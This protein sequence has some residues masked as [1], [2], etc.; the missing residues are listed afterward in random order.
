MKRLIYLILI[1]FASKVNAQTSVY[2]PFP[3]HE[4]VW[5]FNFRPYCFIGSPGTNDYSIT[6]SG[7]TI[8]NNK[9][10]HKLITPYV[11]SS[12]IGLCYNIAA[13]YKGAI[14]QDTTLK[15]VFY[16]APTTQIE[17]LLYDFNM[18]VGDTVKGFLNS[19]NLPTI[20]TVINIDS[21]LVGNNYRKRWKINNCYDI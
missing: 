7:D 19:I 17:K 18:Q 5:N 4:A 8:I 12:T 20:D 15:K 14:R 2:H 6:F 21:V 11:Y 3:E 1:F 13:G 16:C 9:I 10:Y